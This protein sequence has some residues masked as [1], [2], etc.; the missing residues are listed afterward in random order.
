MEEENLPELHRDKIVAMLRQTG[1][2]QLA[3]MHLLELAD[4]LHMLGSKG[5]KDEMSIRAGFDPLFSQLQG[6]IPHGNILILGQPRHHGHSF[7]MSLLKEGG[8]YHVDLETDWEHV[9]KPL[10]KDPKDFIVI[11][12][13]SQ[14]VSDP[15]AAIDFGEPADVQDSPLLKQVENRTKLSKKGRSPYG[16]QKG[17]Q[18]GF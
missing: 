6:G 7:I 4:Q 13:L 18:R 3:G 15:L 9:F 17:R 8:K 1:K 11:D 10:D 16:P 14:L 12:S 5:I 2:P